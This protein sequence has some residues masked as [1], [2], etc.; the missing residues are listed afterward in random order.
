MQAA[1]RE[2]IIS[3]GTGSAQQ[4]LIAAARRQGLRI[5]GVDR[6]ARPEVVDQVLVLSTY[7]SDAVLAAVADLPQRQSIGAVLARTSG[8]AVLTAA[9][10]AD[11]LG[12][13]SCGTGLAAASV[14]KSALREAAE[15]VGVATVGGRRCS[16]LPLWPV[17]GDWVVKPDQPVF[18]KRNVYRVLNADELTVAFAAAA[19]ESLN[20]QVEC[21]PYHAGRDIGVVQ[22]WRAGQCLW[23][24]IYEELVVVREGRFQGAGVR[25]PVEGL[26]LAT[27]TG[28]SAAAARLSC[29]WGVEGF[30]FFS[31]RVTSGGLPLLYEANPGLCGD[32][33]VDRLFPAL[34]PDCDFYALDVAVM[35]GEEPD[36]LPV[37]PCGSAEWMDGVLHVASS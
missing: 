36:Q 22:L 26:P 24:T 15:A 30:V 21:Q 25:A 10:L 34:W 7:D 11:F 29:Y 4:P 8:P 16:E 37:L 19:A 1:M 23:Q 20:A 12:V 32:G 6:V 33:L 17:D 14:A 2:W 13:P 27:Q 18:G 9:R 5:L 3:I 28:L 31:F 35:R